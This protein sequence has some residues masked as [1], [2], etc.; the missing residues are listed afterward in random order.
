[1]NI[2]I[3]GK[4][5]FS[6]T[7]SGY[8]NRLILK[9]IF[10]MCPKDKFVIFVNSHSESSAGFPANV[11]LQIISSGVWPNIFGKRNKNIVSASVLKKYKIDVL[12]SFGEA[13]KIKTDY[14]LLLH[15]YSFINEIDIHDSNALKGI[16]VTSPILKDSILHTNQPLQDRVIL[17]EGLCHP[18]FGPVTYNSKL[19]IRERYT[20]S[21]QFFICSDFDMDNDKF[22]FLL[23]AFSL[24]K[25]RLQSSWKLIV[26]LRSKKEAANLEALLAN[27]KFREDV[28]LLT[29]A[30]ETELSLIVASAYLVISVSGE[31][32]FPVTIFEASKCEVP[33]LARR[34]ETLRK[35]EDALITFAGT[36]PD[37]LAEKMILIYKEESL[38]EQFA[39]KIKLL[40]TNYKPEN[41]IARF[42]QHLKSLQ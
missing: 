7:Q 28:V 4:Y 19:G 11:Q 15:D 35:Y 36:A 5:F 14:C 21:K 38:R 42:A 8:I 33:V 20:G 37:T 24:F 26:A 1:M 2:G 3:L 27:Y 32:T 6:R 40:A 34:T 31:E 13:S 30:E 17:I 12:F 39:E 10:L 22:I 29:H 23:K 16:I 9:K 18:V 25:Q 41:G